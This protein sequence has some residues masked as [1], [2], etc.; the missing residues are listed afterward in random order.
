[1]DE[2]FLFSFVNFPPS[3]EVSLGSL[4]RQ[5]S[6]HKARESVLGSFFS[7]EFHLWSFL[8]TSIDKAPYSFK[9]IHQNNSFIFSFSHFSSFF[10]FPCIKFWFYFSI[11]FIVFSS[12]E[13]IRHLWEI[14]IVSWR[15]AQNTADKFLRT[16]VYML[17]K[18]CSWYYC[19]FFYNNLKNLWL[20][21]TT[22][23]W[24]IRILFP[25]LKRS[26]RNLFWM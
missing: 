9:T 10:F 22:L 16:L 12:Y 3:M 14:L 24:K 25:K 6:S 4:F 18:L 13:I 23:F 11:L 1:M 15:L 17:E 26:S 21:S 2:R 20:T 8:F 7:K 19:Q 5:F